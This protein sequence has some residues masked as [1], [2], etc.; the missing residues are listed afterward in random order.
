MRSRHR[1]S[2]RITQKIEPPSSISS[3]RLG[4]MRVVWMRS[5]FL[6]PRFFCSFKLELDPVLE[7]LDRVGADAELDQMKRHVSLSRLRSSMVISLRALR[8]PGLRPQPQCRRRGRPCGAVRACS[9][10]IASMMARRWP[11]STRSPFAHQQRQHLAVHR[12]LDQAV[13]IGV[14]E[15]AGAQIG[16]ADHGLPAVAQHVDGICGLDRGGIKS[17]RHAIHSNRRAVRGHTSLRAVD[18]LAV[19]QQRQRR[20]RAR[21]GQLETVGRIPGRRRRIRRRDRGFRTIRRGLPRQQF[22]PRRTPPQRD[23][24]CGD[25][26]A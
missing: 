16:A 13:A 4:T 25:R 1:I 22:A 21:A 7:V 5:G 2:P 23:R 11:F 17:G 15:I 3:A 6:T 19:D 18:R 10:F 8:P 26:R 14:V 12:R 9:I 20:W 24:A